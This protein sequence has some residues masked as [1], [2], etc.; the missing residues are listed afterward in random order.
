MTRASLLAALSTPVGKFK[1]RLRNWFPYI[2]G[3][4]H[5]NVAPLLALCARFFSFARTVILRHISQESYGTLI[6]EINTPTNEPTN[7]AVRVTMHSTNSQ[8]DCLNTSFSF[9]PAEFSL[10]N[11]YL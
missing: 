4:G 5:T 9:F 6:L 8:R 11:F 10:G 1:A 3:R 2:A 7:L